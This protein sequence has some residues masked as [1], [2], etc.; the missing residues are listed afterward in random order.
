MILKSH[1]ILQ[2]AKYDPRKS[3][4]A[5]QTFTGLIEMRPVGRLPSIP[6]IPTLGTA[7][8]K[9]IMVSIVNVDTF[10]SQHLTSLCGVMA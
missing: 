6:S 8:S 7:L 1:Q 4:I 5:I 2:H 3:G 9:V 10:R